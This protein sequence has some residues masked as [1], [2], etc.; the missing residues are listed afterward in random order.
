MLRVF[1]CVLVLLAA[2][3]AGGCAMAQQRVEVKSKANALPRK[4]VVA[5][6]MQRFRGGLEQRLTLAEE[7]IALAGKEAA[8]KY[9]RRL[10]L[11]VL[12]E[13]A[14]ST[15]KGDAVKLHGEVLMRLGA[16]AKK[17][18]RGGAYVIVP[19]VLQE[20][21][22]ISNAAVLFDRNGKVM[23][24]YRKVHTVV[25]WQGGIECGAKPGTEYPVFDCDFGKLGIQIC[26]DM[27]F[28][29]GWDALAKKGAE[30]VVSPSASPATVRVAS[31]AL[32][33]QYWVIT[34]T[35]RDNVTLFNPLGVV[36]AQNT[37]KRVM[38][39]EIDLSYALLGW[40]ETL[41]DGEAMK[42]K[43][44]D[45]VG[46]SFSVR[47]DAGLFWS[48]DPNKTIGEMYRECGQREILVDIA[49]SQRVNDAIRG[50]KAK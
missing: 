26:W 15:E 30:L 13:Y 3:M 20:C 28:D 40:S 12:P 24:I 27:M 29:E 48:N 38:V 14:I 19:M 37:T 7:V 49:E 17:I 47:E 16:A 39:C 34:S 44:G 22:H 33:N 21:D 50:G 23:G 10:D 46:Y 25:D 4:V 35:V 6:V 43:Y 41:N 42:Q 36:M 11:V 31:H 1:A 18:G 45:K 9:P 5:T 32:R 2:M 8:A